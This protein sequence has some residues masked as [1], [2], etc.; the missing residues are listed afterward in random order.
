MESPD[1]TKYDTIMSMTI[2]NIYDIIGYN[3]IIKLLYQYSGIS[4]EVLNAMISMDYIQIHEH[5][6]RTLRKYIKYILHDL[7]LQFYDEQGI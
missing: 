7:E 6:H 1:I 4:N 5:E 2:S 3:G